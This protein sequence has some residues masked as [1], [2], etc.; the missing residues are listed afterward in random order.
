MR[1][2]VATAWQLPATDQ[3]GADQLSAVVR[4]TPAALICGLANAAIV[5]VSF[6]AV[7]PRAPLL[8][9]LLLVVSTT[10]GIYLRR[11]G[12]LRET[13]SLSPRARRRAVLA[14]VLL[15]LPWAA[16]S[17]GYLGRVPHDAELVLITVCAGMSAGGSVLLAPVYPAALAYMATI[18]VPFACKC[19]F[20]LGSGY[21]LLGLLA[22]SFAAFLVAVIATTARLSVER[23]QAVRALTQSAQL[24]RDRDAT[25]S[26]QNMRFETALDNM[27]QG[28][29]FFDRDERLIVCNQRY[30][31]MYKLDPAR[32]RPGVS[33]S[34]I[35]EMRYQG[36]C[37]PSVPKEEYHAWREKLASEHR[38]SESIHKMCDGRTFAIH[39]QPMADGAWVATTDDI[40]E[41]QRLSDQ[42]AENH[43]LLAHMASHDGLTGL[44]NRILFR[45]RLDA[46]AEA[47]R[48]GKASVV[49][50][51]LD[52]NK[53]KQVNDTLGHPVGDS[54]LQAIAGRLT[55]CVRSD[56]TVARL[57]G[58]EFAVVVHTNDPYGEAAAIAARIRAGLTEPFLLGDH[59]VQI[60]T[61]IGISASVGDTDAEQL[62]RQA[63]IALYR[64]KRD[65]GDCYRFFEPPPDERM[66]ALRRAS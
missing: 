38:P 36:G 22:L 30:I 14:A 64:A 3:I 52:L 7:V 5:T 23:T 26:A 25:I 56:D 44:P 51:M 59:Q 48:T 47:S 12:R 58:D 63:D 31:E 19:L 54:L 37:C 6:W 9:W 50:M 35:V 55:A 61:S 33:L 16:L 39:Y 20:L 11:R 13:P 32:V 42:L 65:G 43:R 2:A 21:A 18:L 17:I 15:A 10:A 29:C 40:T 24:L 41:R 53:F 66:S 8:A 45:E 60:G 4:A 57:G 46:A 1:A 62:I 27:T 49:V 34:E 28:L